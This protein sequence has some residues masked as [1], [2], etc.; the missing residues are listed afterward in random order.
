M[1]P[2]DFRAKYMGK[3]VRMSERREHHRAEV[4]IVVAVNSLTWSE[5]NNTPQSPFD[6]WV[7]VTIKRAVGGKH[8]YWITPDNDPDDWHIDLPGEEHS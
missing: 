7:Q 5:V 4:G 3:L 6:D 8:S 2:D 1:T